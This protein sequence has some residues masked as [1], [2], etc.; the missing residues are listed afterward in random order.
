MKPPCKTRWNSI[1]NL[2]ERFIR[3]EECVSSVLCNYKRFDL[4]LNCDEIDYLK[5]VMN[6]L[7]Y[8]K[9]TSLI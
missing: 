4:I 1:Y 9:E 3:I 7:K 2:I 8:V 5:S 6:V